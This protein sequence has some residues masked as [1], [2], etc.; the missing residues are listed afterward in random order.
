M[1]AIIDLDPNLANNLLIETLSN[2]GFYDLDGDRISR[3]AIAGTQDSSA[4]SK[5]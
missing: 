5:N 4:N 3:I 1:A 2:R